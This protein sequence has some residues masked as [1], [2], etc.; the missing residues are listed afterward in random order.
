MKI[1]IVGDGKPET[2]VLY[3][4]HGDEPCGYYASRLIR[5]QHDSFKNPVAFVMANEKAAKQRKR[6]VD[7][8]LNRCFGTDTTDTHEQQLARELEERLQGMTVLDLHASHSHGDPFAIMP[9]SDAKTRDL[10][11]VL[12]SDNC[13]DLSNAYQHTIPD[14]TRIAAECGH[15]GSEDAIRNAYAIIENFLRSQGALPGDHERNNPSMFQVYDAV[16]GSGYAFLADNFRKVEPGEM[17]AVNGS[18][19]KTAKEPFYPVLM[20]THGYDGMIGFKAAK[21]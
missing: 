15:I 21:R 9:S 17:Y 14:V 19:S 4:V 6:K 1:E 10:A 7:E 3:S 12:L 8:D 11:S 16:E 5:R 20:S 2:A 13:I 18:A